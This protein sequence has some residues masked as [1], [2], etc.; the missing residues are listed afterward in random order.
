MKNW[1]PQIPSRKCNI[2]GLEQTLI[3]QTEEFAEALC[4]ECIN[5]DPQLDGDIFSVEAGRVKAIKNMEAHYSLYSSWI[6]SLNE[7][8]KIKEKEM[9]GEMEKIDEMI[10]NNQKIVLD[11]VESYF[12]ELKSQWL[13]TY[14]NPAKRSI[15][16]HF[17][18]ITRVGKKKL[19]K[20]KKLIESFKDGDFEAD[21]LSYALEKDVT[22]A[23]SRLEKRRYDSERV[24]H[25][26]FKL[27]QVL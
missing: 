25:E 27:Q 9:L 12:K 7:K 26:N 23:K 15:R 19:S 17:A 13:N 24:N 5:E 4:E 14:F 2:H 16:D 22:A 21:L 6:N 20:V 10:K 18:F 3:R 1:E 11:L 8:R